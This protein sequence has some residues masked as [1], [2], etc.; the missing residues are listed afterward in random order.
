MFLCSV[1]EQDRQRVYNVILRRLRAKIVA[2]E[3]Q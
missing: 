3:K 1:N 2:V